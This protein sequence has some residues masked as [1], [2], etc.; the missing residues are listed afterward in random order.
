[1]DELSHYGLKVHKV[2]AI[3]QANTL[4]F[5]APYGKYPP[6]TKEYNYSP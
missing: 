4:A 6:S 5:D 3:H 2:P 1:M